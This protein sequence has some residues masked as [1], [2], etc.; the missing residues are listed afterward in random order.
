MPPGVMYA[1]SASMILV[2]WLAGSEVPRHDI[3]PS[4]IPISRPEGRTSLAVTCV[5]S[6]Y[7]GFKKPERCSLGHQTKER[8]EDGAEFPDP[9]Q[10]FA[11]VLLRDYVGTHNLSILDNQIKLHFVLFLFGYR[12]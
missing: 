7:T 6:Q 8:V 11:F 10:L 2:F 12:T 5:S 1:P 3:L 9:P 4:L